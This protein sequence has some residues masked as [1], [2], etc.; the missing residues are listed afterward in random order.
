MGVGVGLTPPHKNMLCWVASKRRGYGP[1]QTVMPEEDGIQIHLIPPEDSFICQHK[2]HMQYRHSG[3]RPWAAHQVGS[4]RDKHELP[5][6]EEGGQFHAPSALSPGNKP[7][8]P[9]EHKTGWLPQ[10]NEVINLDNWVLS[11]VTYCVEMQWN[12]L[13]DIRSY[14]SGWL[15]HLPH[16]EEVLGSNVEAS[17]PDARYIWWSSGSPGKWMDSA[18]IWKMNASFYIILNSL[19]TDH[20]NI[21]CCMLCII[22]T[23][24]YNTI[25]TL[26]SVCRIT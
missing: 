18:S 2:Q 3:T 4:W 19:F 14:T 22:N 25:N 13:R 6:P 7:K 24:Q 5:S 20:P 16:T 1:P 9:G 12:A 10:Y 26:N 17:Y 11:R 8:L 23:I 21:Q 15:E